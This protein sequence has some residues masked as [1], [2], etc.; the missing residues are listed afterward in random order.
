MYNVGYEP[1]PELHKNFRLE[2]ELHKNDTA[3]QY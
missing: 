1:E 3:P 2:P